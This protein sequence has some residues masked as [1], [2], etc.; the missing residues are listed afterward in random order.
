MRAVVR[1]R[2]GDTSQLRV[3]EVP[4]PT[5]GPTGVLVE[6]HTS[7]VNPLDRYSM[8]GLPL[9]IRTNTSR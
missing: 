3:G 6:V 4:V 7:N 8:L 2:Y 5:I 1:D 9:M